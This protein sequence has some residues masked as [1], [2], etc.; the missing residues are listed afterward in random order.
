MYFVFIYENTKIKLDE[1]VLRRGER[2]ERL[3][4]GVNVTMICCKH[5]CKHYTIYPCIITIY[6]TFYTYIQIHKY[7]NT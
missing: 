2:K 5:I 7:N 4:E 6:Y 1:I 3:M